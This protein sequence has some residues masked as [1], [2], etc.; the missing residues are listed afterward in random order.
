MN[1]PHPPT[2]HSRPLTLTSSHLSRGYPSHTRAIFMF[3]GKYP[4]A[5]HVYTDSSGTIPCRFAGPEE[6]PHHEN[7]SPSRQAQLLT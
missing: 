3:S 6:E 4:H 1:G 2:S 5:L 7:K